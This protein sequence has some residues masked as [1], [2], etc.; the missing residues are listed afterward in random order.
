L[1]GEPD[2]A[3]VV[4]EA[5][6][7]LG[8]RGLKLHCHVQAIAPDDPRLDVL[9]ER[10]TSAGLPVVVHSGRAPT[11]NGY[12]IDPKALCSVEATRRVLRRHPRLK[13]V[14]P[15]LGADEIDEHFAL[16]AEYEHLYLDTT[17]ALADYFTPAP[18]PMLLEK[19]SRRLLYG[20]DFPN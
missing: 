6:G 14:I 2:A 8:L 11:C 9:Y 3:A 5:L 19:H 10:A 20:T 15:H 4:D 12:R 18:L 7:P 17:M 16:L 1:P 13:M